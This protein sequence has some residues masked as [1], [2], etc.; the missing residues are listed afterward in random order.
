MLLLGIRFEINK[1]KAF[2]HYEISSKAG[3]SKGFFKIVVL[4]DEIGYTDG[5]VKDGNCYLQASELKKMNIKY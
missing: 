4:S 3:N 1:Q 2:E 5:M